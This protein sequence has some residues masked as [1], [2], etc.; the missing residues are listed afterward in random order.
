MT[1]AKGIQIV[2]LDGADYFAPFE[3][4]K[5]TPAEQKLLAKWVAHYLDL[6]IK[7]KVVEEQRKSSKVSVLYVN[8]KEDQKVWPRDLMEGR[9][10]K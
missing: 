3:D 5:H 10:D 7:A 1:I 2:K 6:G 8:Y 4:F 9:W